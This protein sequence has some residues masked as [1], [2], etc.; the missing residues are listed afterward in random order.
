MPMTCHY[1]QMRRRQRRQRKL[2]ALKAK[3]AETRDLKARLRLIEKIRRV[4]P[5]ADLSA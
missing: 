4:D 5:G 2:R 3:L 1:R